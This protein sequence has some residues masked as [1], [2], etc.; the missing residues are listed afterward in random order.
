MGVIGVE[1]TVVVLQ[2]FV[3]WFGIVVVIVSQFFHPYV[4][5]VVFI[6]RNGREKGL[7]RLCYI[8]FG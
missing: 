8:R 6:S 2:I 5:S 1:R 4:S 3:Y 7:D